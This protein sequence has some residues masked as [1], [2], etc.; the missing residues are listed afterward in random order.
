MLQGDTTSAFDDSDGDT[1]HLSAEIVLKGLLKHNFFPNQKKS[2]DDLPPVI[3]SESFEP[4]LAEKLI[5]CKENR[6]KYYSG[7]DTVEYKLTR[8][9]G[10]LRLCS[11]PHPKAYAQL[12]WCIFQ[13][14]NELEYIVEN[15]VSKIVPKNHS[16]GRIIIMDYE[17]GLAKIERSL[18]DTFGL[19]FM[20]RTDISNFYPSIYTHSIP[21]AVV[22]VDQA[23]ANRNDKKAW[24]NRF[25]QAV[26][27]NKRN[28]TQGI[29]IGPA[30]SNVIAETLLA[31]VD[32][33][34]S[35][36]FTFIRYLDDYTAYCESHD[37]AQKFI[38]RLS[39]ELSKF[40]LVLN[41]GKTEIES[42]PQPFIPEWMASLKHSLPGR[43]NVDERNAIDFLDF[44]VQLARQS[45]DGSVLKYAL[46]ALIGV[47]K[48][49]E[50]NRYAKE[51]VIKYAL[52]LSFH[53]PVLFPLLNNLIDDD[54]MPDHNEF[55][56]LTS[57]FAKLRHSDILSWPLYFSGKF[58][59]PIE[60]SSVDQI[61]SSGDCIPILILYLSGSESQ[62]KN[63]IKFA[64]SLDRKDLYVLDQYWLLL[65]QLFWDQ[66]ISNPY[67]KDNSFD[68]MR[69]EGLTFVK[70]GPEVL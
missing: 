31:K 42:L 67:G 22:G 57:E 15:K 16:D 27:L 53:Q 29:A 28:E 7:Y 55:Q 68:I 24:Y 35:D 14:W 54:F 30:T 32:S 40:K 25:D 61:L 62:K 1:A 47:I 20:A 12:A 59:I 19:R 4:E 2:K 9:N 33:E 56:K 26:Q 39:E 51:K 36:E 45:P 3:S 38:L 70:S 58:Q 44:A 34:L 64:R 43:E 49:S 5:S 41:I 63:V 69:N 23:K 52:N 66:K 8:F 60:D 11:I 50:A 65:Y 21:W 18:K 46:K 10:V 6:G 13:N 17:D 37:Q 48:K